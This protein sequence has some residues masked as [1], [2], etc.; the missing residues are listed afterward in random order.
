MNE[1]GGKKKRKGVAVVLSP[2]VAGSCDRNEE[3][4][5]V[6]VHLVIRDGRNNLRNQ[7]IK[8]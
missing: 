8:S 4:F 2:V 6:L 5:L 7:P 3:L 1:W